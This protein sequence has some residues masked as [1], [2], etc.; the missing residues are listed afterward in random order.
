MDFERKE[1]PSALYV[2]YLVKK[3]QETG[4]LI[5]KSIRE[6]PKTV[7][8]PGNIVAVA[9]SVYDTLSFSTIKHFGDIIETN[10]E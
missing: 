2:R 7:H 3:V 4:I 1:T 10:F 9:E 6:K 5:D 8:I